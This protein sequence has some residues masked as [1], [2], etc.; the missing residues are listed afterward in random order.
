MVLLFVAVGCSSE[1]E[2]TVA[3]GD[4]L[5]S[6]SWEGHVNETGDGLSTDKPVAQYSTGELEKS[7]RNYALVH[8]A[9]SF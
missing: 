9:E 5:P 6:L 4:R 1:P 2:P 7:G 8:L 3:E